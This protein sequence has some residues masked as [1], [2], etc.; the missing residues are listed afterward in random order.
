MISR[1]IV[2]KGASPRTVIVINMS[3]SQ[4]EVNCDVFLVCW[5]SSVGTLVLQCRHNLAIGSALKYTVAEESSRTFFDRLPPQPEAE[6]RT[7]HA[8]TPHGPRTFLDVCIT[9]SLSIMSI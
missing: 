9:M 2:Q 7:I 6:R 8:I 3:K 1:T 4:A 5:V